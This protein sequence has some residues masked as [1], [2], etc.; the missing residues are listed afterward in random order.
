MSNKYKLI[1]SFLFLVIIFFVSLYINNF[2]IDA[3][4]DTLIAKN[5]KDF[6]FFN[7][8]QQIFP[9]KNNLVIAI[10]S[11]KKINKKLLKEI[12]TLSNKIEEIPQVESVFNINKAPILFLNKTNLINLSNNDYETISN[13][14]YNVDDVLNEF[15]NSPIY[16]NQI[17]N[18]KKN[19]TSIIIYLKSNKKIN[20]LKNNKTQYILDNTYYEKKS[21]IDRS[22]H[23]MITEIRNILN[24]SSK[25]Y[26]YYLGGV[27]MIS[28]D[29]ISFVKND[30]VIFSIIVILLVVVILFLIFRQLKWVFVVLCPSIL[31]VYVM[32]GLSGYFNFEVTAVSANF[33]SLMF[34]FG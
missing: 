17:I 22:R 2:R 14:N 18:D 10:K 12:E 5:D 24:N 13:N 6:N 1:F 19:I 28:D 25:D 9:T 29:V 27:E 15:V 21:E 8:Y 32:V 20:D 16:S 33:L 23:I 11:N 7:Y 26:E 3:S 31:A 34:I 30:I 4:S